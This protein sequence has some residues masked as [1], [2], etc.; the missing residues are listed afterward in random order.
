VLKFKDEG[1]VDRILRSH[2]LKAFRLRR[3]D[4]RSVVA[5]AEIS[6]PDLRGA[7]EHLGYARKLLSGLELVAPAAVGA[8][9]GA[10]AAR[11]LSRRRIPRP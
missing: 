11:P 7:L 4:A 2:R 1:V 3:I 8:G 5:P 9:V 6:L 10:G